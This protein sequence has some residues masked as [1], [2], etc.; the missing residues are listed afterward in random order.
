MT[1]K[2]AQYATETI[3]IT[4]NKNPVP[5]DPRSPFITSGIRIG[6][7]A[8]TTRG[9][10]EDGIEVI[11]ECLDELFSN[12]KENKKHKPIIPDD[13]VERLKPKI[14][15]L[16]NSYPLYPELQEQF[17]FIAKHVKIKE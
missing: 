10:D 11:A 9:I 12:T 6:T 4:I 2:C 5:N 3:G 15:K 7:P 1:G 14:D 16:C 17:A 8:I 13:V